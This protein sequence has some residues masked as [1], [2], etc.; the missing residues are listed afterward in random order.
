MNSILQLRRILIVAPGGA[1]LQQATQAF[2][3]LGFQNIEAAHSVESA[4]HLLE[5]EPFD[6]IFTPIDLDGKI[7]TF[8]L[9]SVIRKTPVL[10]KVKVSILANR[11]TMKAV[12][13]CFELGALSYHN[14]LL[15]KNNLQNE[16]SGILERMKHLNH[17][18]R[19]VAAD[20]IRLYLDEME[21]FRDLE[22]FE[23]ALIRE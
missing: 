9:L 18:Y 10:G 7:Y 6:W 20:Y 19:L 1:F 22:A 5:V 11:D 3:E 17:D 14:I 21:H 12:G 16:V 8:Q 15:N 23:L 2:Q 13:R 4:F